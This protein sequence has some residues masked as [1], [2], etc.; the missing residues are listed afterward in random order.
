MAYA[1]PRIDLSVNGTK[2]IIEPGTAM[3]AFAMLDMPAGAAFDVKIGDGPWFTVRNVFAFD[4]C[5][6][7][8]FRGLYCRNAIAQPGTI[9]EFLVSFADGVRMA[10]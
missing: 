8:G 10:G 2:T 5:G 4:L 9:V 1:L 3:T 7:D 6:N